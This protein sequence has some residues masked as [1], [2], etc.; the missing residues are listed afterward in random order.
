VSEVF[1][2]LTGRRT[3]LAESWSP[4]HSLFWIHSEAVVWCHVWMPC[5]QCDAENK[6]KAMS[7]SI[8]V[9]AIDRAEDLAPPWM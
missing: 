5:Q 9:E 2:V 1:V 7:S 8:M 4:F 6:K 3:S